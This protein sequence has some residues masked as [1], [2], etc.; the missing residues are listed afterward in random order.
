MWEP[1][2]PSSESVPP[3]LIGQGAEAMTSH[4]P[5]SSGETAGLIPASEGTLPVSGQPMQT[6]TA[7]STFPPGAKSLHPG[8]AA[9]TVHPPHS[10]T[11]GAP[12]G[13][14]L[15]HEKPV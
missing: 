9:V 6:L 1:G 14:T 7:T 15:L 3:P 2:V 13:K 5:L 4:S 10:V 11:P 12:V 8:M